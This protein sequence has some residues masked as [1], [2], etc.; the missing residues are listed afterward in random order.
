MYLF[1]F[2][3]MWLEYWLDAWIVTNFRL[4]DIN[5]I[6]LFRR[7]HSEIPLSRIQDISIETNGVLATFLGYGNI[8]IQTAGEDDFHGRTMPNLDEVKNC[9]MEYSAKMS[10]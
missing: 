5:Q 3:E 1:I 7:E 6:G 4:I 8:R 2:F 9:L 10:T